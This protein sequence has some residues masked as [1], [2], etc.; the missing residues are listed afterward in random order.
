V[1]S[2]I[3]NLADGSAD[4]LAHQKGQT[5]AELRPFVRRLF[6]QAR[7]AYLSA[8]APSRARD[9]PQAPTSRAFSSVDAEPSAL[10]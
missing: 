7:R 6:N 4:H 10:Q 5:V 3:D 9:P 1:A 8:G 2:K